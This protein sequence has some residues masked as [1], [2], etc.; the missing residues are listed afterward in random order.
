MTSEERH[1][2]RS[3]RKDKLEIY[4][5][6]FMAQEKSLLAVSGEAALHDRLGH[7]FDR[8]LDKVEHSPFCESEPSPAGKRFEWSH[9]IEEAGDIYYPP[10][11]TS[12]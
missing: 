3:G 1:R 9:K 6:E 4:L 2:E 11:S 8:L 5:A 10:H 7:F 12:H